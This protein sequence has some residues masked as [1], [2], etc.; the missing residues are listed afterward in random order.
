MSSEATA[1]TLAEVGEWV[2]SCDNTGTCAA[3]NA[4]QRT[5]L[6][7]AHPSPFGMSRLCIHRRSGLADAPEVSITMRAHTQPKRLMTTEQ[8]TL[9]I[10]S[11]NAGHKDIPLE[12]TGPSHWKVPTA[13]ADTLLGGL[14]DDVQ[15]H[16]LSGDDTLPERMSVDGIGQALA[17]IDRA[18][19]RAGTITALRQIGA[20]PGIDGQDQNRPSALV[21]A[22]LPK[23]RSGVAPS[24][25]ASMLSRQ[26]CMAEAPETAVG[27]RLQGDAQRPDRVLWV[28]RCGPT[29]GPKQDVYTIEQADGLAAP[30]HFPGASPERPTG[31]PGVLAA[32][33]LDPEKGL[34]RERWIATIPVAGGTCAIQRLWGWNGQAF[35]LA[36]ERRSLSCA[37]IV[38]GYWPRTFTR[39]LI[40]PAA[41]GAA[42]DAAGVLPPCR[43]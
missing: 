2:V 3:V 12:R 42:A 7:V 37:G 13:F 4:S 14:G 31:R 33:T 10:V 9:R 15:L 11:A 25:H 32:S 6:R 41:N 21:T 18:Q 26:A 43:S 30:V 28:S 20:N 19:Q 24:A 22:Q 29:S 16:I 23:L 40:T 8:R 39:P 27:Y 38:S 34:V 35:E 5:Q 1:Y 17:M 36:E